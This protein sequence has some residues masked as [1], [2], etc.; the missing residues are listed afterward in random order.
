MSPI[1]GR[2]STVFQKRHVD[3]RVNSSTSPL[4]DRASGPPWR[5]EA[6]SL[7]AASGPS[8]LPH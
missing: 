7:R 1:A 3:N 4:I 6:T 8:L 2:N 5:R